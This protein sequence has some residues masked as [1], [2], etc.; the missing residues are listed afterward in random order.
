MTMVMMTMINQSLIKSIRFTFILNSLGCL[1]VR[2]WRT[3]TSLDMYFW[4]LGTVYS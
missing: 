4:A 2:T 3:L 1:E